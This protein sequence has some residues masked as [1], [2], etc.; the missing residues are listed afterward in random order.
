MP[1]TRARAWYPRPCRGPMP[2]DG[3]EAVI[4]AAAV[5]AYVLS[6]GAAALEL[7]AKR[8]GK[9]PG[10]RLGRAFLIVALGVHGM[11]IGAR[12]WR[13]GDQAFADAPSILLFVTA[14]ATL[15]AAIIDLAQDLRALP[16]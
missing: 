8:R 6:F 2:L 1:G 11:L 3:F 7:A 9:E 12:A 4:L 13:L 10:P 15:V 5:F 16:I 14:C